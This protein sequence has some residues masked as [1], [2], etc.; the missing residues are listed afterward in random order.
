MVSG[1]PLIA[2]RSVRSRSRER[3]EPARCGRSMRRGESRQ[4]TPFAA[5][6][7]FRR[8]L[9]PLHHALHVPPLREGGAFYYT[10][11][12]RRRPALPTVLRL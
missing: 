7:L 3:P 8:S 6:S 9:S 1:R 2:D 12:C 5:M 11:L 4:S 10:R